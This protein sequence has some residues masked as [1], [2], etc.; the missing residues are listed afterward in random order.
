V[1]TVDKSCSGVDYQMTA[2]A[3]IENTLPLDFDF[4]DFDD[5][6]T[7]GLEIQQFFRTIAGKKGDSFI[8]ALTDGNGLNLKFNGKFS[9]GVYLLPGPVRQA[10]RQD[11]D[12]FEDMVTGFVARCATEAKFTP[13]MLSSYRGREGNVV[14]QTWLIEPQLCCG[15]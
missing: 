12:D 1:V 6:G 10:T 13:T 14:Y 8:M 9:P 7:P 11:Y 15:M 4:I 5:E 3:F 2:S